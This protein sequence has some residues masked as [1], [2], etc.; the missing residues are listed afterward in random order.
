MNRV[1][2]AGRGESIWLGWFLYA[3]LSAFAPLAESRGEHARATAWRHH[4]A[5]LAGIAGAGR[6]G[7][8]VGIGADTSMTERRWVRPPASNAASIRSRNPGA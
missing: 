7:R 1:G 5:A 8:R 3:A 4:A 6:M 2:E